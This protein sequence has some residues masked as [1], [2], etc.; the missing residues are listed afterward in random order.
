MQVSAVLL[1]GA[2]LIVTRNLSDYKKSPGNA[3]AVFQ[4][5][6]ARRH[7]LEQAPRPSLKPSSPLPSPNQSSRL[8]K[9]ASPET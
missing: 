4:V 8:K 3:D 7:Y 9:Q 5:T 1:S 6:I 2:Q